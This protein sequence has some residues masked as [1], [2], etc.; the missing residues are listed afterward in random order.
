MINI[1]DPATGGIPFRIIN[2]DTIE[3]RHPQQEVLFA[4]LC[5]IIKSVFQFIVFP[6]IR[7]RLAANIA[8]SPYKT[9]AIPAQNSL[10]TELNHSSGSFSMLR[11]IWQ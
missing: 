8:V 3:C 2:S 10:I 1:D 9:Q 5:Y 7:A 4:E 11:S 6:S